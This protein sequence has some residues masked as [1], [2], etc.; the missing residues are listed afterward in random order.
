MC[1]GRGTRLDRGE[2]P[3][4]PVCGTPMVERVADACADSAGIETTYAAV[5]P[6]APDTA[7]HV[8]ETL[9]LPAVET[10]GE[11]Y[12]AD[13]DRALADPRLSP[14][15]LTVVADLPLLTGGVL[16]A[17][18]TRADGGSLAVCV[19]VSLKRDL[20]VSVD[21][22]FDHGGRALAPTGCNV[23][24]D[25][26]DSIMTSHDHRLAV[27]VNRPDDLAVAEARCD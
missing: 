20:G 3:L 15:L 4:V 10:P 23:V 11:G 26:A 1:G 16:D 17:V 5:S 19:P 14:P 25:D 6:H 24:S 21:T 12:V 8:R 2:K 18:C 13:L 7:D 9:G 22:R 27:N